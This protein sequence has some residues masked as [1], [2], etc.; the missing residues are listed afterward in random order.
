MIDDMEKVA[1]GI[2]SVGSLFGLVWA[3]ILKQRST[4][5]Q[6]QAERKEAD[7][8]IAALG[9][10]Q[11]NFQLL[12]QRLQQ[13]EEDVKDLKTELEAERK[14]RMAVENKLAKLVNW[15]SSQGLIPPDLH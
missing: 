14:L 4:L 2:G 7:A 1:V 13:M 6:A 3:W 12:T 11:V 9:A 8:A 15:I 10:T 5:K